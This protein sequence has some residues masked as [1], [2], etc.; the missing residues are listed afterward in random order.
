M[1]GFPGPLREVLG[2]W[3]EEID[4]LFPEDRNS[5]LWNGRQ[6]EVYGLCELIHAEGDT[7]ILGT[8]ED[9]FYKGNPAITE[10]SYGKGK[11]YF[12]AA[13]TSQ[14]FLDEFYMDIVQGTDGEVTPCVDFTLPEGVS[15]MS[16]TDGENTYVFLM[17]FLNE[18]AA[19]DIEAGGISLVSGEEIKEGLTLSP[20]SFEIY[21][22]A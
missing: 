19:L 16:R 12:I 5:I 22:K 10:N 7:K 4:A 9:D 15:A 13:R 8:Y 11:A 14:E 1:G 20:I 6:Y 18:E 2:V 3:C 17:N 21:K